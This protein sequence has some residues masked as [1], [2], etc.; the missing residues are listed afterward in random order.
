MARR[1]ADLVH[2][3]I[4]H[5]NFVVGQTVNMVVYQL[6]VRGCIGYYV[7]GVSIVCELLRIDAVQI[8]KE[9]LCS[10]GNTVWRLV[11]T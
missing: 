2:H 1:V 7:I 8:A 3:G 6:D 10:S 5:W 9:E 11:V 4:H